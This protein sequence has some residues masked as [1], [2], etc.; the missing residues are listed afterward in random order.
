[1]CLPGVH[2]RPY[3]LVH[4]NLVLWIPRAPSRTLLSSPPCVSCVS[5]VTPQRMEKPSSPITVTIFHT[6]LAI[7]SPDRTNISKSIRA[8][9]ENILQCARIRVCLFEILS[10]NRRFQMLL[11]WNFVERPLPWDETSNTDHAKYLLNN[12]TRETNMLRTWFEEKWYANTLDT[13]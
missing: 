1:M 8:I 10:R 12:R 4:A 7:S 6:F 5:H 9:C 2:A 11:S 3:T 13:V